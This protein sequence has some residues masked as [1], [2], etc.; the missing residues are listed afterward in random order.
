M[1]RKLTPQQRRIKKLLHDI[2]L[3]GQMCSNCCFNQSQ[4]KET[5]DDVKVSMKSSYMAW[6]NAVKKLP[7]WMR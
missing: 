5:P 4:R 6:D 2:L 3:G 7:R 1:K